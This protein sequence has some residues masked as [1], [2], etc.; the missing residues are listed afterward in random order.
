MEIHNLEQ[1]SDEWFAMR[2]GRLTA[3]QYG[4]VLST[5]KD[6]YAELVKHP[7]QVAVFVSPRAKKQTEALDQLVE[8]GRQLT[9]NL[10]PSGLAA[11]VEKGVARVTEREVCELNLKASHKHIDTML[12]DMFYHGD[13]LLPFKPSHAMERG[14][15][16]EEVARIDFEMRSGLNV[17][18]VGFVTNDKFGKHIGCSPDGLIEGQNGGLEIKCP[19]PATHFKYHREG[20]V[21]PEYR[22]QVHGSMA[23]CDADFWYFSSFCPYLKDFTLKVYKDEYTLTLSQ[24]LKEFNALFA[25][26]LIETKTKLT[27][28]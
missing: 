5:R 19:L 16:L 6:K 4:K 8:E 11:L 1:C 28:N 3:S 24:A 21:P 9:T 7:D 12:A 10:S 18:E 23:V 20:V 17:K 22:A 26:R 14:V 13:D 25:D 27:Q 15:R 2:K